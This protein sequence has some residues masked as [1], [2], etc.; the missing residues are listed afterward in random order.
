MSTELGKAYVQIVPTAKGIQASL[1]NELG[2]VAESAGKSAGGRFT[3]GLGKF[4]GGAGK[5][6]LA[7]AV[8]GIS[9]AA[10]GVASLGKRAVE[11]YAD[12]QQLSGG[13]ETL[14]GDDAQAVMKSASAAFKTA[15]LSANEY[16]ETAIQ[17]SASLIS[18]LGGDTKAA[19]QLM[20]MSI[21][22]MADN[23]NKM[24]T[25]MEAVQNAYRGFSRGNFTMLDNL[26]LGYAGTKE[27]ME[28]LLADAQAISGVKYDIS[29]YADMVN[30][31][32]VVQSEM[33]ITGTTAKEASE[34]ISGSLGSMKSAWQN[35]L[36]GIAN[37]DA[38]VA[39]LT[40][41]F[42][43]SIKTVAHNLIPVVKEALTG[44]S[45]LVKELAPVLADELPE[46]I[47][48]VLPSLISAA[49][50]LAVTLGTALAENA[51]TIIATLAQAIGNNAPQLV[52]G[53]VHLI[54][55]LVSGLIQSLPSILTA[56]AQLV[57]ALLEEVGKGVVQ[58]ISAGGNLVRGLWEGI[59]GAA[60]WLWQQISG[61]LGGIWDGIKEFF[62]IASPSKEMAW[63][64]GM[65]AEGL[66][67]G[68]GASADD[69]ISAAARMNEGVMSAV[70]GGSVGMTASTGVEVQHTGTIRVEGVNSAGELVAV[71]DILYDQIVARLRQEVRYAG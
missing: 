29:S 12:F 15:G 6:A 64:G 33:G 68:I 55:A 21:T 23:V 28:K 31:I 11:S 25:S 7:G 20:D 30:A 14:Y 43:G 17:S 9:A 54:G 18:S 34:T 27:G 13:I 35:L 38:D 10:A 16:M 45:T 48:D 26:A 5:V 22:D 36:T 50:T 42:A 60:A 56:G 44:L 39:G 32:H 40:T 52:G 59:S 66:A 58:L 47:Q 65:L 70:A 69:A 2:G 8:A 63:A 49:V 67:E 71:T 3:S 37:G 19:S 51:P 57:V 41:Q 1:E 24:G 62:G 46:L 61:W 53:A 4:F